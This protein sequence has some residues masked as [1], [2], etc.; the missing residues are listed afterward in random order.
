MK[1]EFALVGCRTTNVTCDGDT[2]HFHIASVTEVRWIE[3]FLND[4]LINVLP[5][6]LAIPVNSGDILRVKLP[7]EGQ[8]WL[9]AWKGYPDVV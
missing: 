4:E 7:P 8:T 5:V 9:N 6:N 3:V 2:I 1:R